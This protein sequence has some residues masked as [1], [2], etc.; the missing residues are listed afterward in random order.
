VTLKLFLIEI[1]TDFILV[2]MNSV[3]Y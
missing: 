1:W 3:H 2:N